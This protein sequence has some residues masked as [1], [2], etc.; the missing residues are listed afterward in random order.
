M[1]QSH[2]SSNPAYREGWDRTFCDW[3][4]KRPL[5]EGYDF[6]YI[7]KI[8]RMDETFSYMETIH[9]QMREHDEEMQKETEMLIFTGKEAK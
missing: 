1:I 2:R 9:R 8:R 5:P 4:E 3:R 6:E 7:R